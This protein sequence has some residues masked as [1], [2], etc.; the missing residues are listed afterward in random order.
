MR[1]FGLVTPSRQQFART[2]PPSGGLVGLLTGG[3]PI[4]DMTAGGGLAAAFDGV[5]NTTRLVGCY[6]GVATGYVRNVGKNWGVPRTVVFAVVTSPTDS[7]VLN[8][9]QSSY[10]LQGSH[11]GSSW[12]TLKSAVVLPPYGGVQ[13]PAYGI[14]DLT[15]FK[16][17]RVLIDG[18]AGAQFVTVAEVEF[19]GY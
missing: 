6:E 14:T 16:Y 13:A 8:T 11:D 9:V 15:P 4:G 1:S 17:H 7:G 5:F 2:Y 19:Y 3:T 10:H 12:T 18:G